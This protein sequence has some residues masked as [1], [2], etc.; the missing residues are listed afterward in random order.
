MHRLLSAVILCSLAAPL[1]GLGY[2]IRE[3]EEALRNRQFAEVVE[4]LEPDQ[5][6][7]T[8]DKAYAYYLLGTA[9][10][11]AEESEK[12]LGFY[13]KVISDFTDSRWFVKATYRKAE[14]LML[15]KRYDQ[16]EVIYAR[17]TEALLSNARREEIADIYAQHADGLYS[18]QKKGEQPAY[19]RAR[20]LYEHAAEILPDGLKWERASYQIAMTH[21]KQEQ[22]D[23]AQKKFS[24]LISYYE[25]KPVPAAPVITKATPEDIPNPYPDGGYI[26]DAL[27]HKGES[28]YRL[29]NKVEARRIWKKLRDKRR[30]ESKRPEI[31]AEAA[32]RIAKTYNIPQPSNEKELAQGIRSLDEYISLFPEHEKVPSAA[33]EKAQAYTHQRQFEKA[34]D[35]FRAVL[36]RYGTKAS[37][38]QKALAEFEIAHCLLELG[39]YDAATETYSAFLQN[40][41]VDKNWR[42][43]QQSIVT[44]QYRKAEHIQRQAEKELERWNREVRSNKKDPKQET[45]PVNTA[46]MYGNARKNWEAFQQVYPL[47]GRIPT[48]QLLLGKNERSLQKVEEAIVIWRDVASRFPQSD[49]ASEALFLIAETTESDLKDTEKALDL[50]KEVTFGS[51]QGAAQERIRKLQ[52]IFLAART[53]HTFRSDKKPAVHVTTRNIEHLTCKLYPL[54]QQ[55][56]FQS[57]HTIRSVEDLD[58]NLIAPE[59]IWEVTPEKY[60]P[61]KEI[62]QDIPIPAKGPGAWVVK[63]ESETLEAVTLVM[64]SDLAIAVKGGKNEVFVY[65]EDQKHET[66]IEDAEIF[67]SDGK[68]ILTRGK[69]NKDG[70]FQARDIKAVETDRLSIFASYKG[71]WAGEILQTRD[72]NVAT[73]LQPRIF[74]YS[75]RP[76]YQPGDEVNY[77]AMIRE[78]KDGQY[79]I[80]RDYE[81]EV[82][83]IDSRGTVIHEQKSNLSE[84]GTLNGKYTLDESAPFGQY[85]LT[86]SRKD[87]PSGAW[88][89]DVQEF[90]LPTARVEIETEKNTFFYGDKISGTI[91]VSDFSGNPFPN[92]KVTYILVGETNEGTTD[93]DGKI[94]FEF[95]TWDLPE[96]GPV[97]IQGL[98]PNRQVQGGKVVMLVNTGFTISLD[99]TRRIYLAGEPFQVR[100]KTNSRDEKP[101]L[102]ETPLTINLQKRND[103]RV[104][105][106]V[107]T[108]NIVTSKDER[109]IASVTFTVK[110]GGKYRIIA[111]GKDRRS[112]P[113]TANLGL[114]ISDE[115]D[116]N[117]ILVL[118]DHSRYQQGEAATFTVVSR[119][120]ENL[121]LITGEREG[122]VEYRIENLKQGKN[123]IS[124]RLDDRYSPNAVVSVAVMYDNQFYHRD[125]YFNVH[126]GL[127]VTITPNSDS[128]NPRDEA[129]LL[130]EAKDHTGKP[131]VSELS[132]GLVDA[133]LL[134]LFPD[135]VEDLARFFEQ[136]GGGRFIS[137]TSSAPFAYDGV[138]RPISEDILREQIAVQEGYLGELDRSEGLRA[139]RS[140]RSAKGT[141]EAM[142]DKLPGR[143][144]SDVLGA[145]RISAPPRDRTEEKSPESP[146]SVFRGSL[147]VELL[148]ADV[149]GD[150]VVQKVS[151]NSLG[152]VGEH[153]RAGDTTLGFG[154]SV[155]EMSSKRFAG[156]QAGYG[157]F[158]AAAR[159]GGAAKYEITRAYFPE[160]AYFNPSVITDEEGKATVHIPLPD[161]LTTW[162]VQARAI[163]KETLA[164]QAKNEIVVDRPYRVEIETPAFLTEGDESSAVA[165][166]RNNTSKEQ[167]AKSAFTQTI[168]GRD[169]RTEWDATLE[170]GGIHK[171]TV[172]LSADAVGD[173]SLTI[174]SRA[175]EEQ[176]TAVKSISIHPWGIPIRV[177]E[178]SVSNQ[179]VVKELS[180]PSQADYSKLRMWVDIGGVGDISLIASTWSHPV[181]AI[182]TRGIIENGL[183]ALAALDCAEQLKKTGQIPIESLRKQVETAVR[184]AIASQTN[185]GLWAWGGGPGSS[186]DILTSGRVIE[187]L[188][189]AKELGVHIPQ[190]ILEKAL[191]RLNNLYQETADDGEKTRILYAWSFI[192]SPDFTF[193]N[194]IHRNLSR[195][196]VFDSA[197][198]GL[199]WFNMGRIEKAQEVL[200]HLLQTETAWSSR[201]QSD[202]EKRR[203]TLCVSRPEV[204]AAIARLY[205]QLPASVR[206]E[207]RTK[208]FLDM[209]AMN[210]VRTNIEP[211]LPSGLRIQALSAYLLSA[212]EETSSFAVTLKINEKTIATLNTSRSALPYERIEIDAELIKASGNRVEFQFEGQGR[213]RYSVVLEGWTKQE[214]K[215]QD[216]IEPIQNRLFSAVQRR[217]QHGPL[218]Y[219]HEEIPRGYGVVEGSFHTVENK[220]E[221]VPAGDRIEVWLD[222]DCQKDQDYIVIED[223]IPAGFFLVKE[224][225]RGR[226]DH[227]FLKGN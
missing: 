79:I 81:F 62:V 121:C 35:A 212:A 146:P 54:D 40:H 99:T 161:S 110:T 20:T 211:A 18:P 227:Y 180:L 187:L 66:V 216:W 226:V 9:A 78:I 23:D 199:A 27:L 123:S 13:E 195:L 130:I 181:S 42:E 135:R 126:R 70:V 215:P 8:E 122:I 2:S 145:G 174:Q 98:L 45:I 7:G 76:A 75:D 223:R 143:P 39:E 55:A 10:F 185:E 138:T 133:A 34:L 104:Y 191:T 127:D 204:L 57:K 183:A 151:L 64:S 137:T 67:V 168:E 142:Y 132:L 162:E 71:H 141:R 188:Q 118:N 43:A 48:I 46:E 115:D 147:G 50:Y 163:T 24:E 33:L 53:E 207:Q 94:K 179:S 166:V 37:S 214:V 14:C 200:D 30:T 148:G 176:D 112:T 158:F 169:K 38:E 113:V 224:S 17:G 155:D 77:R 44:T 190:D 108:K 222:V 192:N 184:H 91:R 29:E 106:T 159:F 26:D 171:K 31:I 74:I 196:E 208:Q 136:A 60:E 206:N 89:F 189:K 225:I 95:E 178:S 172:S 220:L 150:G 28:F 103:E 41:P 205:F 96:E 134:A 165:L 3:A 114:T 193:V 15:L 125:V 93:K 182:S 21:F 209:L 80:P 201:W 97:P 131:V 175:G 203:G 167:K 51:H 129:E 170:P 65:A 49:H 102:L 107:E 198:L 202:V 19:D 88:A 85:R 87:G 84:F 11:N 58:I 6:A 217:Y 36:D 119:L 82:S 210:S 111:E 160:T 72:L 128:Y 109:N 173:C 144:A 69:T 149:N 59:T 213:Y 83:L 139:G 100:I 1:S 32:Y 116:T 219:K 4:K 153:V 12:A 140:L 218:F 61:H 52:E 194:R 86:V 25:S 56:Y 156:G 92:E 5:L 22:W 197:L 73:S 124:W 63:I 177:G 101:E 68:T 186:E 154:F 47:D 157:Y 105:E 90:T 16:A 152:Y 164:N 221:E 120:P 117:K